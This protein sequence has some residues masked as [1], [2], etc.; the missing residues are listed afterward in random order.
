MALSAPLFHGLVQGLVCT[1]AE[2]YLRERHDETAA[3]PG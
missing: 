1:G 3:L 2:A